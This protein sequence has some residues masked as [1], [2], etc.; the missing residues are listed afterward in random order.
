MRRPVLDDGLRGGQDV[1]LVEGRS[2]LVGEGVDLLICET[3]PSAREAAIAASACARTGLETWVSFTAGPSGELMTPRAMAEAARACVAEGASAV[4]VN[5]VAAAR[6]LPFVEALASVH[7]RV[8]A[9]ANASPWNEPPVSDAE[10]VAF[11]RA[12]R[13]AGASLVGSC[14]GTSPATI[15]AVADALR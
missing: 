12:W 14:C 10:Y 3:F 7:D 2:V 1:R 13:D 4:L 11:A 8:G 5:C 6:T 15:R 9:Y